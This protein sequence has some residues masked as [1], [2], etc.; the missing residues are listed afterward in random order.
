[1]SFWWSAQHSSQR[2][3]RVIFEPSRVKLYISPLLSK[4]KPTTGLA[5]L[6]VSTR[7]IALWPAVHPVSPQLS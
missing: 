5:I 7:R 4:M 3:M 1:M 6:L 2:L